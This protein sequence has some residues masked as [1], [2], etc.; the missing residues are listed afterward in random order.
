MPMYGSKYVFSKPFFRG[1]VA[2]GILWMFCSAFCVGLYPLWE[3]RHTMKRTAVAIY[4]DISGRK[5]PRLAAVTE[6]ETVEET[7]TST[8]TEKI[9]TEVKE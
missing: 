4:N 9:A 1:W 8:P 2:V 7:G 3:G 6:G 5:K